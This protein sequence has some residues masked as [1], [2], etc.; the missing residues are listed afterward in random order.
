MEEMVF[1]IFYLNNF[2]TE[3]WLRIAG[4]LGDILTI[5]A[6]D[7]IYYHYYWFNIGK[8]TI[9]YVYKYYFNNCIILIIF[10]K[11]NRHKILWT[12]A[13]GKTKNFMRL[14]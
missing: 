14:R 5:I 6:L 10:L 2:K 13:K 8:I 11:E 1:T 3:R 9:G 4:E 12:T 7:N